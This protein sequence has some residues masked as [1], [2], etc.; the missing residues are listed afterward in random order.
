MKG[1]SHDGNVAATMCSGLIRHLSEA[2]TPKKCPHLNISPIVNHS[3]C[4][5]GLLPKIRKANASRYADKH[6]A[7][8]SGACINL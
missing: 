6:T 2:K 3:Q 1:S 5:N 4:R 8:F 7:D